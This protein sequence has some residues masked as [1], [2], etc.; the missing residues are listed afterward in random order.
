MNELPSTF[1]VWFPVK[2]S[3]YHLLYIN[4]Y[5]ISDLFL[6]ELFLRDLRKNNSLGDSS[7]LL[8]YQE[9]RLSPLK[10]SSAPKVDQLEQVMEELHITAADSRGCFFSPNERKGLPHSEEVWLPSE[11]F[12]WSFPQ[13]NQGSSRHILINKVQLK[14]SGRNPMATRL[15]RHH[16]WGGQFLW[17]NLKSLAVSQIFRGAVPM[18]LLNTLAFSLEAEE[19]KGQNISPGLNSM[20]FREAKSFRITQVMT[21]FDPRGEVKKHDL[22]RQFLEQAKLKEHF[23]PESYLFNFASMLMMGISHLSINRENMMLDGSLIDYEDLRFRG[24]SDCQSTMVTFKVKGK[25]ELKA[26]CRLDELG[27]EVFFFTSN[28]NIYLEGLNL[29]F[30]AL[31]KFLDTQ[32][33][34][35]EQTPA[36]FLE[37]IDKINSEVY[38]LDDTFLALMKKLS[39][40]EGSYI[41]GVHYFGQDGGEG[42]DLL[43]FIQGLNYEVMAV[44]PETKNTV[45]VEVLVH[46][47]KGRWLDAKMEKMSK[48]IPSH[49][50][51]EVTSILLKKL[52]MEYLLSSNFST[53]EAISFSS[54]SN[55][56]L[57]RYAWIYPYK[58]CDKKIEFKSEGF[59]ETLRQIEAKL[60]IQEATIEFLS[61]HFFRD[62]CSDLVESSIAQVREK[63]HE[64]YDFILKGI[65]ISFPTVKRHYISHT[66]TWIDSRK[67]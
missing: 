62:E 33:L 32:I 57:S 55:E 50:I 67:T 52:Q 23:I 53:Q 25:S 22:S 30:E 51:E 44:N 59:N 35:K 48:K 26:G 60:D 37:I 31:S 66:P 39:G 64:G 28:F 13:F 38:Q 10:L 42:H 49:N 15:D 36:A 40:L 24:S 41:N 5:Y 6:E 65:V 7:Q 21:D 27:S 34:S 54:F 43:K 63:L 12:F 58:I 9:V 20:L 11:R 3:N 2:K 19:S 17:Q 45:M 4:F 1:Y 14:G 46:F 47:P 56:L 8:K 61:G 29:T 16:S 18:D